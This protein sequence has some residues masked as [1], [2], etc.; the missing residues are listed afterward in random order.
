MDVEQPLT[1]IF[2][3]C[4]SMNM[5]LESQNKQHELYPTN[6]AEPPGSSRGSVE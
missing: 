5:T 6:I 3:D 1:S 2:C 4:I